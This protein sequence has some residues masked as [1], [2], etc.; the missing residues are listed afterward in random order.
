LFADSAVMPPYPGVNWEEIT[1]RVPE[2]D[3]SQFDKVDAH[4]RSLD[5]VSMLS[6]IEAIRPHL[7]LYG[8]QVQVAARIREML[9]PCA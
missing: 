3:L 6:R 8:I 4:L 5:A 2:S 9:F 1:V 7:A